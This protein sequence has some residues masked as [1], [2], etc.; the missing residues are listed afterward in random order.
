LESY[1]G[2]RKL[3]KSSREFYGK[4]LKSWDEI[5]GKPLMEASQADLT[6]WFVKA[7]VGFKSSTVTQY[8]LYLRH[9]HTF[10]LMVGG[11]VKDE[12]KTQ[13]NRLFDV[14]PVSDLRRQS[15]K[16]ESLRDMIIKPSEFKTLMQA[17]SH[18]RVQAILTVLYDSGGRKSE[19]LDL[20]IRDVE[21]REDHV[22]IRVKGKTGER[23]IPL[24]GSLPYL[25]QWLAV[26]P[27]RNNLDSPLFVAPMKGRLRR[28]S[29]SSINFTI[30]ELC[31]KAGIR[32]LYPHQI[33]HT[34]LT[35]LAEADLGEFG[36]KSFAGWS[37]A[38]RQPAR[39]VHLSG[40]SHV[41]KVL[42]L[43]GL[44]VESQPRN[45]LAQLIEVTNCPQCQTEVG[46]NMTFC[47]SC[48][49]V[50]DEKLRIEKAGELESLKA[51]N[52]SLRSEKRE[53]EDIAKRLEITIQSLAQRVVKLEKDRQAEQPPIPLLK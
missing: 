3:S 15:K 44:E 4:S 45:G 40:K 48:G 20:R 42:A 11:L 13:T 38:S 33:R 43:G 29:S 25:K 36:L 8:Q 12:A 18:P 37:A 41:D 10:G 9:L 22:L 31:K 24:L 2:K 32:H 26:H 21:F 7:D 1:L 5:V 30:T 52:E 6:N 34:R 49:F 28:M 50:L 39:Y 46:S 35:D 19:I 27:D 51:E 17:A 47:P 14:I 23:T 53:F 16:D